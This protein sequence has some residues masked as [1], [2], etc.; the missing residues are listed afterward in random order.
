MEVTKRMN[1][2]CE[3]DYPECEYWDLEHN[4]LWGACGEDGFKPCETG[5]IQIPQKATAK[6]TVYSFPCNVGDTLY[7]VDVELDIKEV[8]PY[9]IDNIVI[10]ST[11]DVLFRA[12]AYDDVICTLENLTQDTLYLDTFKI[13]MS[14]EEAE[15]A[16]F[17]LK[18]RGS[19]S[20]SN[21]N[22][23]STLIKDSEIDCITIY[24]A[25]KVIVTKKDET[26]FVVE[27]VFSSQKEYHLLIKEIIEKNDATQL[28]RFPYWKVVDKNS[29]EGYKLSI[30]VESPK[31]TGTGEYNVSFKKL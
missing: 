14:K 15:K 6:T 11:G 1:P 25:D 30:S 22:W 13:F 8:E 23:I 7:R 17:E 5:K 3:H 12:D 4:C 2:V 24:A 21:Y 31:V 28:S 19:M 26:E 20:N 9:I 27:N 18:E 16:L 29:Y 10:C